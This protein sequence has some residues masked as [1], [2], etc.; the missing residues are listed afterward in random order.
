MKFKITLKTVV[1]FLLGKS[2]GSEYYVPTFREHSFCSIVIVT[3]PIKMEQCSEKSVQNKIHSKERIQLLE[4][5][6]SL[7]S[8][9]LKIFLNF[10][11]FFLPE[12]TRLCNEEKATTD[13][14][15]F[16]FLTEEGKGLCV[17]NSFRM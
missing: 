17:S 14:H 7:K 13:V 2:S 10:H 5:G 3:T 9:T 4:Y 1:F 12:Y 11:N 6:E 16:H 15:F 8:K